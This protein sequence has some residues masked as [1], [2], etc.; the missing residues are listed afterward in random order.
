M[1]ILSVTFRL[2]LS[3]PVEFQSFSGFTSRGIFYELVRL[4]D[5]EYAQALHSSKRLSPFSTWPLFSVR[6]GRL[7]FAYKRLEGPTAYAR[8]NVLDPGLS[9]VVIGVITSGLSEIRCVK[10]SLPIAEVSVEQVDFRD[11]VS[12]ASPVKAFSVNFMTPC[13]F[14]ATPRTMSEVF[15]SKTRRA[16]DT[17]PYRFLPLPVPTLI[18]RS[19]V[20]IWR[21]FSDRPLS[22]KGFLE[23]VEAGGVAISG[24]PKGIRTIRVY[25]HPTT[26]KWA[27]GFLG[28]VR[29]SIPE[30]T[31][32]EKY[33]AI[34]DILLRFAEYSNVGGNRTAGFGVI[35]YKPMAKEGG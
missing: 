12:R 28:T 19:L 9:N 21:A 17:G 16:G 30:D 10:E 2:T 22:Y 3:R 15:P 13:Y 6:N 24:F 32:S 4:H 26:N 29:F 14:R 1:P 8:I 5:E 11:L 33:A 20:R 31:Y 25:E 23:W 7:R 35:K 18:F 34:V 27:V